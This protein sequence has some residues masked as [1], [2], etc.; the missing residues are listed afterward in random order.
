[1]QALSQMQNRHNTQAR[2]R[3]GELSVLPVFFNLQGKTVLVAGGTDAAA[4]KSELLAASG[5]QVIVCAPTIHHSFDELI[6][7]GKCSWFNDTW[8]QAHFAGVSLALCDAETEAEAAAFQQTAH[9]A[10]VPANVIDKPDY[11]D[12]QFG[13]IVNRSPAVIAITTNGAAPILGQAIR[14]RIEILLPNF[15]SEWAS[16]AQDIRS[17]VTQRLSTGFFR[18]AF[19]KRFAEQAFR[20][21]PP[22]NAKQVLLDDCLRMA[23]HDSQQAGSVTLVGAGPGDA[24][25]LT[26]KAVRALQAADVILFDHLV[27][28]EV[29]DLAR[30]EARRMLVGKRGGRDSCCQDDINS[31]MIRLAHAG[32]NVVRLKGGDPMIFGRAGEELELLD[33]EGISVTVIPG[34]TAASALAASLGVSLTHRDCAQSV[35]FITGHSRHG[36]LPRTIDWPNVASACTTTIF[37]MGGRTAPAISQKLMAAGMAGST[38]VVVMSSISCIDEQRWTGTLDKLAQGVKEIGFEHPVLIGVGAVFESK[39]DKAC[40]LASYARFGYQPAERSAANQLG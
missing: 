15:I 39:L 24:E 29:L 37:Y 23:T 21:K 40:E 1:M 30:R 28:S 34:I 36:E 25:L 11:C 2:E 38:P 6:Q 17:G 8:S 33:C 18:R 35:R 32:K 7:A 31:M 20:A 14:R 19:W 3:I 22:T 4:W 10:G 27:S 26:L 9:A 13:S 5:A 16:L 12:F